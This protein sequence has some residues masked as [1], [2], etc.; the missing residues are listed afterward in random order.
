MLSILSYGCNVLCVLLQAK[1]VAYM[2]ALYT[3]EDMAQGTIK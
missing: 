1:F 2:N 3:P